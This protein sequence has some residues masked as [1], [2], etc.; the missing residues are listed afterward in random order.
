MADNVTRLPVQHKQ[1]PHCSTCNAMLPRIDGLEIVLPSTAVG[2][3]V[4]AVTLHVRCPCGAKWDLRKE[5]QDS[6]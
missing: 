5:V 3:D 1:T 4:L 6:G 2:L